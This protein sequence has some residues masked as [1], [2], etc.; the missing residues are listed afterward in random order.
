MTPLQHHMSKVG[1]GPGPPPPRGGWRRT[2]VVRDTGGLDC[3]AAKYPLLALRGMD[4][5]LWVTHAEANSFHLVWG[6][7]TTRAGEILSAR[8][9]AGELLTLTA[10]GEDARCALDLLTQMLEAPAWERRS[11]Y[12]EHYRGGPA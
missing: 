11:I 8:F 2:L 4:V 5:N 10:T 7:R 1:A 9:R 12:R 3:E 6:G